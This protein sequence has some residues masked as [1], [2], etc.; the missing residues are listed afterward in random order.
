M[1][2]R[3]YTVLGISIEANTETGQVYHPG[4]STVREDWQKALKKAAERHSENDFRQAMAAWLF[5]RSA[6]AEAWKETAL[7]RQDL[8]A[9]VEPYTADPLPTWERIVLEEAIGEIQSRLGSVS[10]LRQR[11]RIAFREIEILPPFIDPARLAP[12][13]EVDVAPILDELVDDVSVNLRKLGIVV[14]WRRDTWTSQGQQVYSKARKR[15]RRERSLD[16][17]GEANAAQGCIELALSAW[18]AMDR[19]ERM[20]T[21]FHELCHFGTYA[22][23]DE[24]RLCINPHDVETFTAEQRQFGLRDTDEGEAFVA[25]SKHP[26]TLGRLKTW[27][28][29]YGQLSFLG[30]DGRVAITDG[31]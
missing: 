3:P 11:I 7:Y 28:L 30:P 17:A 6:A 24:I 16:P 26:K 9:E 18:L 4:V 14:L 31:T 12:V 23:G 15:T 5:L 10:T 19:E 25:A 20:R 13:D 2:I 21:I 22:S 29:D 1:K 8:V 27:D